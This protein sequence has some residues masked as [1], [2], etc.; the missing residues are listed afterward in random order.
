MPVAASTLAEHLYC[1]RGV[2]LRHVA[3]IAP[4]P[5]PDHDRKLLAHLIRREY[6][7]RTPKILRKAG[8]PDD[9]RDLVENEF[10]A[11]AEDL[12]I[13]YRERFE[14]QA[15]SGLL[16]TARREGAPERDRYADA[17][18]ALM[19]ELG[20]GPALLSVTP[21]KSEYGLRSDG[22]RLAGRIDK[23]R[24]VEGITQPVTI[25]TGAAPEDGVWE[26]ER[27]QS[28]AYALLLEDRFGE[29]VSWACVEYTQALE[30]RLVH[31][32]E[33]LRRQTLAI[34]DD[35]EQVIS[36]KQPPDICPH[37]YGNRC[38]GCGLKESCYEV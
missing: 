10:D 31:V 34:R 35:V 18:A 23:V 38:A 13:V 22:L 24:K 21:W 6:S 2:W 30:H 17:L 25:R 16:A 5:T 27:L 32:T 4:A 19:R 28:A 3:G 37:G 15:L 7:L 36:Q 11:L 8:S 12:P 1:P 20:K 29:T 9:I 14:D 33:K 26:A